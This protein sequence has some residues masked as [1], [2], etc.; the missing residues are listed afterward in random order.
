MNTGLYQSQESY[1]TSVTK[2]GVYN[3]VTLMKKSTC[4]EEFNLF[5]T[6][7]SADSGVASAAASSDTTSIQVPPL[8]H[9][10]QEVEE[11]DVDALYKCCSCQVSLIG[12]DYLDCEWPSNYADYS[13]LGNPNP[14]YSELKEELKDVGHTALICIDCAK[15]AVNTDV[16]GGGGIHGI[17]SF[18]TLSPIP[19]DVPNR[20]YPSIPDHVGLSESV[21][22]SKMEWNGE[23]STHAS[24]NTWT[25]NNRL[26]SNIVAD[27]RIELARHLTNKIGPATFTKRQGNDSHICQYIHENWFTLLSPDGSSLQPKDFIPLELCRHTCGIGQPSV[28]DLFSHQDNS[29]ESDD[30]QVN[31]KFTPRCIYRA[32][33]LNKSKVY[34]DSC[35]VLFAHHGATGST[36]GCF[37]SNTSRGPCSSNREKCPSAP[38]IITDVAL[39]LE[40][41]TGNGEVRIVTKY[42]WNDSWNPNTS[43]TC[44]SGAE[45]EYE[46]I[47]FRLPTPAE[48]NENASSSPESTETY[49]T[50]TK[51]GSQSFYVVRNDPGVLTDNGILTHECKGR[52]RHL[53]NALAHHFAYQIMNV[54]LMSKCPT[55][56]GVAKD[57]RKLAT[58]GYSPASILND[59]KGSV[60][61]QLQPLEKFT[62]EPR[63]YID[64]DKYRQR[65]QWKSVLKDLKTSNTY[66]LQGDVLGILSLILE[67]C[68]EEKIMQECSASLGPFFHAVLLTLEHDARELIKKGLPCI[69]IPTNFRFTVDSRL[70]S[71]NKLTFP[72]MRNRHAEINMVKNL[73]SFLKIH[74]PYKSEWQDN[75]RK[76]RKITWLDHHGGEE[77]DAGQTIGR[78][79]KARTT[80][81]FVCDVFGFIVY[82]HVYIDISSLI[83]YNTGEDSVHIGKTPSLTHNKSSKDRPKKTLPKKTTPKNESS[84]NNGKPHRCACCGDKGPDQESENVKNNYVS[85]VF[86]TTM[87]KRF[88]K[89]DSGRLLRAVMTKMASNRTVYGSGRQRENLKNIFQSHC[90]FNFNFQTNKSTFILFAYFSEGG[91]LYNKNKTPKYGDIDSCINATISSDDVL[92]NRPELKV[93]LMIVVAIQSILDDFKDNQFKPE[94]LA[95]LRPGQ[96][97]LENLSKKFFGVSKILAYLQKLQRELVKCQSSWSHTF[98]T[99][100]GSSTEATNNDND[101]SSE[102]NNDNFLCEVMSSHLKKALND[103]SRS[104]KRE[105]KAPVTGDIDITDGSLSSYLLKAFGDVHSQYSESTAAPQSSQ[106]K[107]CLE[108]VSKRLSFSLRLLACDAW[109][110]KNI[111]KDCGDQAHRDYINRY[112]EVYEGDNKSMDGIPDTVHC[113]F[114]LLKLNTK[115][116]LNSPDNT[117]TSED[118]N[119]LFL[120]IGEE[121]KEPQRKF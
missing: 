44:D 118:S 82:L 7:N 48:R 32:Q 100:N 73:L 91:V 109:Y 4:I 11:E 102:S 28:K 54:N 30:A 55:L 51:P 49:V 80:G 1:E 33:A 83:N 22:V 34:C 17:F 111:K 38:P 76:K 39:A 37:K 110:A 106:F 117:G 52:L 70:E 66:T 20:Y 42:G 62:D 58:S 88:T 113:P 112:N 103:Y 60:P 18:P 5:E 114:C 87:S 16:R 93:L 6:V 43:I 10:I 67:D 97:P 119:N 24:S 92:N 72:T 57:I 99:E 59:V 68:G 115:Q 41:E 15:K 86:D 120:S 94:T 2:P 50:F 96:D 65:T 61:P 21:K 3:T 81:M 71:I 14:D 47:K 13:G 121:L 46:G 75:I 36:C 25:I 84:T 108:K 98:C 56:E 89:D 107:E 101:S 26:H 53:S 29:E 27:E 78:K 77:T 90:I 104:R 40:C 79:K 74:L 31:V 12:E 9:S 8:L 45:V 19:V 63:S 105:Y 116:G 35:V 69:V 85:G 64:I 23:S 95:D